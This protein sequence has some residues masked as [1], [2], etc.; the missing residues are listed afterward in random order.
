MDTALVTLSPA[1]LKEIREGFTV[2]KVDHFPAGYTRLKIKLPIWGIHN[3]ASIQDVNWGPVCLE[4]SEME[5]W[6]FSCQP[7]F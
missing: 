5:E 7:K 1:H 6:P 3:A 2:F 4:L